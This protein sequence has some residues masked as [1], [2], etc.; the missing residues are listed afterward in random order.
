MHKG[1]STKGLL[2]IIA[3]L[4]TCFFHSVAMAQD[5]SGYTDSLIEAPAMEDSVMNQLSS[6]E[7]N[8]ELFDSIKEPVAVVVRKVPDTLVS[9]LKKDDNYWYVNTAP[10]R[11]KKKP[12]TKETSKWYQAAWFTSLLWFIVVGSFIA[13]II[14]FLISSNI[15]FFRKRQD[16]IKQIEEMEPGEN[17]F[18]LDYGRELE[19]ALAANDFRLA[20]RLW[21][22]ST[23]KDLSE[24]EL[25]TYNSAKTN[26]DY[27]TQLYKT[28]LYKEF[29]TLTRV[30]EYTWYGELPLNRERYAHLQRDFESFKEQLAK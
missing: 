2:H 19:K 25:I 29:F 12:G 9:Q 4:L 22:L 24:K 21:Y 13:I 7:G 14:W 27:V 28:P 23:L 26:S 6:E 17:I 30:F 1:F 15:P 8:A 5:S 10:E 20:I 11:E 18:T 3:V 16:S